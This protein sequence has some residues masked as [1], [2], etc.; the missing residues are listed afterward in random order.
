MV[1]GRLHSLCP[2]FIN[3]RL[4]KAASVTDDW[5]VSGGEGWTEAAVRELTEP[6]NSPVLH[7][8]VEGQISSGALLHYKNF[9]VT[10][11]VL[12]V[13]SDVASH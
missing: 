8:G 7:S 13:G 9:N 6:V 1:T 5:F 4:S 10:F 11:W 3:I 12:L 2:L